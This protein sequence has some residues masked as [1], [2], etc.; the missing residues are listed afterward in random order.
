MRPYFLLI[1]AALYLGCSNSGTTGPVQTN[2][3]DYFP[4][5]KGSSW[6]YT[7][8]GSTYTIAIMGDSVFNG[9][10]YMLLSNTD[11]AKG[12]GMYR[13]SGTQVFIIGFNSS[14]MPADIIFF[15]TKENTTRGN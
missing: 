7:K 13:K 11:T 4:L 2:S 9:N 8:S 1:I 12:G 14:L 3:D 15:Y 6:T 5:T 10:T